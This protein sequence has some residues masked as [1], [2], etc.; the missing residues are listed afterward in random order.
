M[1]VLRTIVY[2]RRKAPKFA[3]KLAK[4]LALSTAAEVLIHHKPPETGTIVDVAFIESVDACI[5]ILTHL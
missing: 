3:K 4:S 1:T 2:T 5:K